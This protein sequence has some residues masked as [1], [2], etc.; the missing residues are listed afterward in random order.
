MERDNLEDI[1]IKASTR[2]SDLYILGFKVANFW[3]LGM[4][5]KEIYDKNLESGIIAFK[6]Y[7][8]GPKREMWVT[9]E[10]LE[11]TLYHTN[12]CK[13]YLE[14]DNAIARMTN[15]YVEKP[16]FMSGWN[17]LY[18]DLLDEKDKT[19]HVYVK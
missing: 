7:L 4:T 9:A 11:Q 14:A 2:N 13:T 8:I 18:F 12:T 1:F 19:Y 6:E 5:S 15:N 16:P 17:K 3:D 10:N